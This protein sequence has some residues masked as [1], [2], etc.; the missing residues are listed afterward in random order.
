MLFEPAPQ[1]VFFGPLF[2]GDSVGVIQSPLEKRAGLFGELRVS[3]ANDQFVID[4]ET[5]RIEVSRAEVNRI[6]NDE[7]FGVEDLGLVLVNLHA[8]PKQSQ[9]KAL[10]RQ[11]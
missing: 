10:G 2:G 3:K 7:E 5:A 1:G 8:V 6:I 9:I 4:V 11:P